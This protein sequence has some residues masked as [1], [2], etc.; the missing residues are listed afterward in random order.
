MGD[1]AKLAAER[2]SA[3]MYGEDGFLAVMSVA[4]EHADETASRLKL[5]SA[6]QDD[7]LEEEL[8]NAAIWQ[9]LVEWPQWTELKEGQKRQVMNNAMFQGEFVAATDLRRIAYLEE[10]MLKTAR[11]A[12]EQVVSGDFKIHISAQTK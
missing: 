9:F 4:R 7:F 2:V 12:N 3:G 11:Q 6:D 5:A 1:Q 10:T 8:K